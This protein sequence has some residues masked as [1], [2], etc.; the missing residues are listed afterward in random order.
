MIIGVLLWS[1]NPL[2]QL[3]SS[4]SKEQHEKYLCNPSTHNRNTENTLVKRTP[5]RLIIGKPISQYA[6]YS[7]MFCPLHSNISKEQHEK[8]LCNPSSHYENILVKCAP[9]ISICKSNNVLI[10][11]NVELVSSHYKQGIA[12]EVLHRSLCRVLKPFCV[13]RKSSPYTVV[14]K[15]IGDQRGTK[16]APWC[17]HCSSCGWWK[18]TSRDKATLI[19]EEIKSLALA[20]FELCLSEG[21]S[22]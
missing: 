18:G 6:S 8:H 9:H 21:I 7:A 14:K 13:Y 4:I 15:R 22:K 10:F 20:I 1:F 5:Q 3:H 12:W 16:V 2:L 11:C 17:K 19:S